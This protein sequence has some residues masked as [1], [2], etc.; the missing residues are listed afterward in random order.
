[1][2]GICREMQILKIKGMGIRNYL[3]VESPPLPRLYF[4]YSFLGLANHVL[5]P[6]DIGHFFIG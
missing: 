5:N 6:G 3:L 1:M 2:T 4:P